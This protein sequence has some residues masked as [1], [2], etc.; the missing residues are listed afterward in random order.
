MQSVPEWPD[1]GGVGVCGGAEWEQGWRGVH[2]EEEKKNQRRALQRGEALYF[3][4]W[5]S[6]IIS[7]WIN[8]Y[9]F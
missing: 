4:S 2:C 5:K 3:V 9:N 1:G 6:A 7:S 8:E